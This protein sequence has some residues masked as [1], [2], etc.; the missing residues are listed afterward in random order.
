MV[1]LLPFAVEDDVGRFMFLCFALKR[2][3]KQLPKSGTVVVNFLE[4]CNES[5]QTS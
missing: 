1:L 4:S 3:S 5:L 2:F